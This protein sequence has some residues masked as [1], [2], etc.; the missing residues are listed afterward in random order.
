MYT[1]YVYIHSLCYLAIKISS[2]LFSYTTLTSGKCVRVCSNQEVRIT[3]SHNSCIHSHISTLDVSFTSTHQ[4]SK[5]NTQLNHPCPEYQCELKSCTVKNSKSSDQK[6]FQ[7]YLNRSLPFRG[8]NIGCSCWDCNHKI[9]HYSSD[10]TLLYVYWISVVFSIGIDYSPAMLLFHWPAAP[11]APAS[12]DGCGGQMRSVK[13][14]S[15]SLV[16][17]TLTRR[18]KSGISISCGPLQLTAKRQ[19]GMTALRFLL[20][21]STECLEICKVTRTTWSVFSMRLYYY[22]HYLWYT[23]SVAQYARKF[24]G[25]KRSSGS[26]RD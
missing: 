25:W 17:F 2:K 21:S 13:K 6:E 22:C 24:G 12:D 20:L 1:L 7:C 26:T 14:L 23:C 9:I 4:E 5:N 19:D 11:V 8:K 16:P 15:G 10:T 18:W 3:H